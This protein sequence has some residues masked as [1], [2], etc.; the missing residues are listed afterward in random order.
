MDDIDDE[1]KNEDIVPEHQ[2][3][4]TQSHRPAQPYQ[5]DFS[6]NRYDDTSEQI[7][8]QV[9]DVAKVKLPRVRKCDKFDNIVHSAMI[10]LSLEKGLKEFGKQ[11]GQKGSHR[12]DATTPCHGNIFTLICTRAHCR[13]T[14]RSTTITDASQ[15]EEEWKK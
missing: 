2:M 11:G 5:L 10:Q 1:D 9:D 7:H 14:K 15:E 8:I 13:R 3:T 4:R 6:N 12:R